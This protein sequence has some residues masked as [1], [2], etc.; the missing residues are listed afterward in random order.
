[1]AIGGTAGLY[2]LSMHG[3]GYAREAKTKASY[4][5]SHFDS[6]GEGLAVVCS[7][8]FMMDRTMFRPQLKSLAESYRAV[9]YDSR[10]R[11]VQGISR[12]YDLYDLA[13]DCLAFLDLLDI[14]RCVLIGM[15]MGGWMALRFAL[16][17][18][19]RLA[20]LVLID[21]SAAIDDATR[22]NDFGGRFEALRGADTL[23]SDYVDWVIPRMFGA[24][25][26]KNNAGLVE[27]W[28]KRFLG[29]NGDAV[30][31]EAESWRYRDD[32]SRKVARIRLP[33]L[34][35]HGAQDIAE[36]L[37]EVQSMVD[38]M[39]N[40]ELIVIENA[41]HASNLEQP[42]ATNAAIGRFLARIHN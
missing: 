21:S 11:T 10:A 5:S 9:A 20:G 36:P 15:S 34:V 2:G 8:G 35:L 19:Q 12:Q 24:W 1:M 17:Y 25:T 42:V 26:K 39:S 3:N 13:D 30:Y 37:S 14:R 4:M 18:P 31:W 7:H 28:R 27:T 16:K 41:G 32:L 23:P 40:A 29:L 33:I 6:L 22:K 38:A